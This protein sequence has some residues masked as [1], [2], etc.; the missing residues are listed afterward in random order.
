M[1]KKVTN[2]FN[3]GVKH[4]AFIMDGNGRWAKERG[5]PRTYGHNEGSKRIFDMALECNRRHIEV[6][7]CYAFS[8]EN[9]SRPKK[10][11]DY[12][13]KKLN[14]QINRKLPT[15][16]KNNIKVMTIGDLTKLPEETQRQIAKAK[17]ETKNNTGLVFNI[18]LNYGSY[19]EMSNAVK[20]IVEDVQNNKISKDD[21][22]GTLI[23]KY[24]ETGEYPPV[25]LLI[26]TSGEKRLS[27]FL[28]FQLAYTELIFNPVY[29]PDYDET[30]LEAD[31]VEFSK[32]KRRFGGLEK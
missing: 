22:D 29:W 25:D 16:M 12:L 30:Q 6:M 20:K 13:F 19:E 4:I 24:L 9:W 3:Y 1:S 31:L 21:I 10:E 17:E 27:N 18:A 2:D 7:T 32:R 23:N 5:K 15:L 26:R 11:I 28:L 14:T 8:T